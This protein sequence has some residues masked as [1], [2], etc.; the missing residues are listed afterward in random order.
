MPGQLQIE[1]RAKL[2]RD[3]FIDRYVIPARPVVIT[4]LIDDWPAKTRWTPQYLKEP[5]GDVEVEIQAERNTDKRYEVN[6]LS[7]RKKMR[8][9]DYADLVMQGGTTN[10]YYLTANNEA[11]RNS[12]LSALLDDVGTL[13]VLRCIDV[14]QSLLNLVWPCRHHYTFASRHADAVPQPDDGA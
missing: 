8:L 12:Q 2:S 9:A 1:R 10:D 14:R 11:L 5:F 3:E 6:K 4:D 13:P 7:L